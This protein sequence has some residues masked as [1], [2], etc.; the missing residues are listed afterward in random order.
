MKNHPNRPAASRRADRRLPTL[1]RGALAAAVLA[2]GS[3]HAQ[4]AA[5]L[6]ERGKDPDERL[7]PETAL[8]F[9]LPAYKLDPENPDLLVRIARQ[10]RHLM[11]D[12]SSREEKIKLGKMALDFSKQAAAAG[13][14]SSSA[15][16]DIA[17]TYGKMLPLLG[18]KEKLEASKA[19]KAS[20]DRA[21]AL[22]S[23]NDTAWYLLGRWHVGMTELT[24]VR[25]TAA[26]MMYGEIPT[27]TYEAAIQCFEK[28]KQC[29][30]TRPMHTVELGI[31]FVK[32]GKLDEGKAQLQRGLS[33]PNTDKDDPQIKDRGKEALHSIR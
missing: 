27:S 33:M 30:P 12:V 4:T 6:I 8:E 1:I 17:I 25:R 15:Q 22:D 24:G 21:L 20:A 9:Y 3:V 26:Q 11:A 16:V 13:P 10:Y 19:I 18:S 32:M 29:A 2:A 23:H 28:G 5:E 14:K 31:T 7:K